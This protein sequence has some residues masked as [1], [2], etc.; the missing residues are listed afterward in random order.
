MA[1]ED[2]SN[3]VWHDDTEGRCSTF[4]ASLF[5]ESPNKKLGGPG[6]TKVCGFRRCVNIFSSQ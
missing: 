6:N 1:A 3:G 2:S 5:R 4:I